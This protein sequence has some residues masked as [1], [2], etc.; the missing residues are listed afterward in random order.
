[1]HITHWKR[2]RCEWVEREIKRKHTLMKSHLRCPYLKCIDLQV[3]EKNYVRMQEKTDSCIVLSKP[4]TIKLIILQIHCTTVQSIIVICHSR[5]TS[6]NLLGGHTTF[7]IRLPSPNLRHRQSDKHF[8]HHS[9]GTEVLHHDLFSYTTE[10]TTASDVISNKR[11]AD[12]APL[13]GKSHNSSH[14]NIT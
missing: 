3:K 5:R 2:W 13:W 8:I 10:F 9:N 4:L 6:F 1:M 11:H 14:I 7:T 12:N